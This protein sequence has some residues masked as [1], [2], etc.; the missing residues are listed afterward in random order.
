MG[1]LRR[2]PDP[3]I[4]QLEREIGALEQRCSVINFHIRMT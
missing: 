1:L 3:A 2:K 4:E